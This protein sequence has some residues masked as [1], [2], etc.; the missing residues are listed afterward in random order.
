MHSLLTSSDV[1]KEVTCMTH[2][3][4]ADI[5]QEHR[6]P[7]SRNLASI[8]VTVIK[9]NHYVKTFKYLRKANGKTTQLLCSLLK[10]SRQREYGRF[11]VERIWST[12]CQTKCRTELCFC[13]DAICSCEAK[14]SQQE[15]C[16]YTS[17]SV[18]MSSQF[19][20]KCVHGYSE[21]IFY[22]FS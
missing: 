5:V 4:Q 7:F 11:E 12:R 17:Y 19:K 3:S 21:V 18:N 13:T 8:P 22:F 2:C 9:L 1:T 10:D 16:H 20:S 6:E 14:M 15:M